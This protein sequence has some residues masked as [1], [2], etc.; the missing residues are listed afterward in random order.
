MGASKLALKHA[1]EVKT[2]AD[3]AISLEKESK[4]ELLEDGLQWVAGPIFDKMKRLCDLDYPTFRKEYR[5]IRDSPTYKH[6]RWDIK[7][8][9]KKAANDDLE[10]MNDAEVAAAQRKKEEE[11]ARDPKA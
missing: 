6:Y 11:E 3:H 4:T 5:K 10:N 2:S 1:A 9:C 8:A 7:K